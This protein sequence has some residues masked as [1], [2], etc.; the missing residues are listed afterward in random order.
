LQRRTKAAAEPGTTRVTQTGGWGGDSIMR[1]LVAFLLLTLLRQPAPAN[2]DA[3][4]L[5]VCGTVNE[6]YAK[7]SWDHLNPFSLRINMEKNIAF[8]VP[9]INFEIYFKTDD[10]IHIR[11]DFVTQKG[12]MGSMTG[13]IERATGKVTMMTHKGSDRS[14][15]ELYSHI[16]AQCR[17]ASP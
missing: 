1:L 3:S 14:N 12:M 17:R 16:E 10:E 9:D 13:S 7:H 6:I 4:F 15:Y 5:L 2:H 11:R 8:T